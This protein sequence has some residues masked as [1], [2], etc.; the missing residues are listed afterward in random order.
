VSDLPVHLV[1]DTSAIVAYSSTLD[2][3]ETMNEVHDNGAAFALPVACLAEAGERLPAD[4]LDLVVGH[5]AAVVVGLDA[6]EWR[7]LVA[8][9]HLF[10]RLDVAAAFLAA[11][12]Y[13]CDVLT[14]EP[15][16]YRPL[17]DDPPIIPIG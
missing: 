15:A 4:V 13:S 5:P 6:D 12:G 14:A 2:V 1:F 17:G 10:G 7:Q 11:E 9:R 16:W 8:V 3:G